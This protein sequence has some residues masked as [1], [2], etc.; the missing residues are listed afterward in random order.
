[1]QTGPALAEG[2]ISVPLKTFSAI[3]LG[4]EPQVP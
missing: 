3:C 2:I 4:P 1:L